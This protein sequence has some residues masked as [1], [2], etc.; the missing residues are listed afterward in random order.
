MYDVTFDGV[1][2]DLRVSSTPRYMADFSPPALHSLDSF[3]LAL[4]RPDEG[5]GAM[6]ADIG[7][8]HLT[9][10]SSAP[11]PPVPHA[12][13]PSR[14]GGR[15]RPFDRHQRQV[16]IFQQPG[17]NHVDCVPRLMA[18]LREW[19]TVAL[20]RRLLAPDP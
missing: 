16:V 1:I 7:R 12:G 2:S 13:L 20:A 11:P 18:V 14:H 6:A 8:A 5:T 19:G 4:W 3:T 17:A 15:C 9:R 10:P